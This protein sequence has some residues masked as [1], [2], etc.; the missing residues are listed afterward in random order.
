MLAAIYYYDR[1][2]SY[3][4]FKT[5]WRYEPARLKELLRLGAPI[6]GQIFVEIAIFGAVT[7]IISTFGALQLAGHQIALDCASFTFMVPMGISTAASVRV[8]QGIGRCDAAGARAAGWAAIMLSSIFMLTASCVFI[9]IPGTIARGFSPSPEVIA[10]ADKAGPVV[11]PGPAV[12]KP[13]TWSTPPVAP[14]WHRTR[15]AR[16]PS[17]ARNRRAATR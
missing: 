10:A 17:E 16:L 6:G 9:A 3:G 12:G 14:D 15:H 11:K 2:H 13:S 4:L 7:A 5:K 1:R 8:G